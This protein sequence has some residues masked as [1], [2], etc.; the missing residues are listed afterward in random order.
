[1]ER[2][3]IP[4]LSRVDRGRT[5][6]LIVAG[7]LAAV[8]GS[9]AACG[10]D[11]D[12]GQ[13]SRARAS[14]LRSTLDRVEEDVN[15]GNCQAAG[16]Q[17]R[18]LVEQAGGLPNSI[19]A[20]L[21]EALVDSA[22]RLQVLVTE[23]CSTSSTEPSTAPDSGVTAETGP[24]GTTDEKENGDESEKK[25]TKG[26]KKDKAPKDESPEEMGEDQTGSDG[27]G[28]L[29]DQDSGGVAP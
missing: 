18:S 20:D 10:S 14:E 1:M 6:S 8:V 12:D 28:G 27:D 21:R 5:I 7:L 16:T 26:P 29:D 17:A 15:T 25:K 19:D 13:L 11:N 3:A 9:L 23:S 22:D 4:I 2:R 24:T